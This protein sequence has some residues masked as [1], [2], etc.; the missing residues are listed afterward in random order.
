MSNNRKKSKNSKL[1]GR[2]AAWAAVTILVGSLLS[3][4]GCMMEGM[5]QDLDEK[6]S[7]AALSTHERF[8]ESQTVSSEELEPSLPGCLEALTN[9]DIPLNGE[10]YLLR[11]SENTKLALLTTKFRQICV[12][13]GDLLQGWLTTGFW[14]EEEGKKDFKLYSKESPDDKASQSEFP[15]ANFG[16]THSTTQVS[17][18]VDDSNPLPPYPNPCFR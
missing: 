10:L 1:A 16:L 4:G 18:P 11:I 14:P 15:E 2:F 9:P 17:G 5:D 3:L 13:D 7:Q 6:S 12:D 8:E